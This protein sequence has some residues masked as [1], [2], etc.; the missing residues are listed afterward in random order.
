MLFDA[1]AASLVTTVAITVGQAAA[2]TATIVSDRGHVHARPDPTAPVIQTIG[3]AT[4]VTVSDRVHQGWRLVLAPTP[5]GYILDHEL[6]I[7]QPAGAAPLPELDGPAPARVASPTIVRVGTEVAGV[8][9]VFGTS[10]ASSL[11][12]TYGRN[13][14][15]ALALEGTVGVGVPALSSRSPGRALMAVARGALPFTGMRRHAL[16]V[17]GGPFLIAGGDY[18]SALFVHAELAYEYR[19]PALL[20]VLLGIGPDVTLID[21]SRGDTPSCS[22]LSSD[23]VHA[24][25]TGT[26]FPHF[27]LGAGLTF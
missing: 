7:A 18:G 21:S 13:L 20:T 24:F 27:R 22:F 4:S 9:G 1:V 25:K 19:L 10:H 26:V 6:A 12:L 23:C 5:G 15:E 11:G 16:T 8:L 2:A 3:R 17:A 14:V